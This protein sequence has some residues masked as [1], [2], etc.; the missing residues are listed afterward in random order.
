[1]LFRR[2]NKNRPKET[3]RRQNRRPSFLI[4]GGRA[5]KRSGSW[6]DW[7][8]LLLLFALL[9]IVFNNIQG[10]QWIDPQPSLVTVLPL[11]MLTALV[12]AR[13][14]W[15]MRVVYGLGAGLGLLMIFWQSSR[16]LPSQGGFFLLRAFKSLG[17]LWGALSGS[18]PS[19]GTIYFAVFLIL[20]TWAVAFFATWQLVRRRSVWYTLGLGFIALLVNLNYLT[21]NSFGV[22]FLYIFVAIVLI[23]FLKV[24][25]QDADL[26]YFSLKPRFKGIAWLGLTLLLLC[27]ILI[28]GIWVAP[29]IRANQ[30]QN[31]SDTRLNV[32]KS[33]D[34][35]KLNLFAPVKAKG[36]IIKSVDQG[37][38]FFSSQ[39]NLSRDVQFVIS[40]Q[41][42]PSYWRVRR[43]D[44]YN[45]WGWTTSAS[46]SQQ[47]DSGPSPFLPGPALNAEHFTYTVI[48]KLKTDIVLSVGQF[49]SADVPVLLHPFADSAQGPSASGDQTVSVTTLRIYK[50]DEQYT[51]TGVVGVP[52]GQQLSQAG[53]GYPAG[54]TAQYL[55]LPASLPQSVIR[56]ARGLAR[57]GQT[58][59]D[60]VMAVKSYLSQFKYLINGTNPP[61][62]VDEVEDFL[63]TQK[64]GNCTNFATAA[65]VLLRANGIPARLDTGY[66]TG[67]YDES[68]GTFSVEAKDYHAWPEVYFP[69]YGW[70]QFEVTPG[71]IQSPS[72]TT[73]EVPSLPNSSS[74]LTP[75]LPLEPYIPSPAVG[76]VSSEP[77][78]AAPR[79]FVPAE[80][81]GGI[82][83]LL[84]ALL[85]FFLRHYRRM[86][87]ASTIYA[88]LQF[89]SRLARMAPRPFQ[90]PLE[91]GEEL[92]VAF[93]EH[94]EAI[95]EITRSYMDSRYGQNKKFSTAE[96]KSLASSWRSVVGIVFSRRFYG[97]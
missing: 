35:L 80:V 32:A 74:T 58:P 37:T 47:L 93:P 19:E 33:I 4:R 50:P 22:F 31:L 40:S 17:A 70:V 64:T 88:R 2:N 55:Q 79:S 66:T 42:A 46:G 53:N 62:G 20:L 5:L 39:P 24:I 49:L 77:A 45:S 90:T 83:V 16:V 68:A 60:T 6:A 61:S 38:L 9:Y 12:V 87:Y 95:T 73:A 54:I 8:A 57:R 7:V 44:I 28:G 76:G 3:A 14:R 36:A 21:F 34:S 23:G 63:L 25:K 91:F 27:A 18:T 11:A 75:D 1:V 67:T 56:I 41:A 84:T 69:G 13:N 82:I 96:I 94:R 89:L 48:D 97:I 51:V 78:V 81:A 10:A 86:D 92:I 59:Y 43:Y 65:V 85:L 26:S 15:R 52:S 29:E 72:A 71:I 30:L